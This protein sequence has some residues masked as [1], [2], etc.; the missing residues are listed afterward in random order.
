VRAPKLPRVVSIASVLAALLLMLPQNALAQVRQPDGTQVPTV[1]SDDGQSVSDILQARGETNLAPPMTPYD[2]QANARQDPQTFR[3]G[4]RISFRVVARFAG[5]LDAFGWYNVVPGRSTPP[6]PTERYEIVPAANMSTPM[7][8]GGVGFVATLNIGTD[9]RYTGGDIGFFLQ[10]TS[11]GATL[12]TERR[13]Q[14]QQVPNYVYALI[15]DSRVTPGGFYFAWEDLIVGNDNDFN[16]LI[17]LVDNL[18]CT[19][20]GAACEVPGAMGVCAQ[21]TRQCRN[22][23]LVCVASQRPT[24]EACDGLD[25]DCDGMVDE[26]DGLCPERQVCDRGVCVERCSQELG[27]L[28]G[29]QCSERGTCVETACVTVT[30]PA[31]QVCRGGTCRAPC[32]GVTCPR[33]QTCRQGRCVDPCA[34]L[35]CDSDQVCVAGVCVD[36]CPCRRCAMGEVCFTDGRCRA[37]SCTGVS[38]P[39]GQ[40]CEAGQCRDACAGAVCPGGGRCEAGRC[41]DPVA[42]AGVTVD[43]PRADVPV[44]RPDAGAVDAG[45]MDAGPPRRDAG[46][47]VVLD[48]SSN[49]A[50][51]AAL[52][53]QGNRGPRRGGVALALSAALGVALGRRRRRHGP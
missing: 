52:G 46:S 39:A 12:Y 28:P 51:R 1:R 29:S 45:A 5:D 23:E 7:A 37:A 15:Y 4:C 13:Y 10:N 38:C 19:G 50:C 31:G 26:G 18:T 53:A 48:E 8:G 40:Y 20:G 14:P 9:P 33:G 21:G 11:S 22:A 47:M 16:D 3:P 34:G 27:C 30:C 44:V 35:T 42:D 43:V 41:L 25:N 17:V 49:C 32:D 24:M 2:A 6:P 36:R